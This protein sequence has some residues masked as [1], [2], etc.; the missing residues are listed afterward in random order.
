MTV[1]E[2]LNH[3]NWN[4]GEKVTIDSATLMNKGL[5]VIEAKWLF[6][7]KRE[8]ISVII[9]PQSI[10]HSIVEFTDGLMNAQLGMPDMKIPIQYA[11]SF[12]H[13]L[14]SD[15][16]CLDFGKFSNLTFEKPD[17]KIFR[18]L[19]LAYIALEKGGN[20]PCILNAANEIAVKAFLSNDIP[21]LGI[22]GII[23][24]VMSKTEYIKK[25]SLNDYVETDKNA[26]E[27][28]S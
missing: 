20:F 18:N 11:L 7:L 8:Q 28:G 15:F 21:F 22:P 27:S 25:P 23:E 26:R 9:H 6:R 14:K 19:A 1:R 3:P 4:M 2:T 24:E 13:R 12:P 17:M 10:I 5:E 16:A